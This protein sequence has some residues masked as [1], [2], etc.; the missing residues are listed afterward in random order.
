MTSPKE[1]TPLEALE[2]AKRRWGPSGRARLRGGS[3]SNARSIPGRLARYRFVVGNGKLGVA[4][5]I[6]GQGDSWADAFSDSRPRTVS[7]P[8][9]F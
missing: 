3:G 6:L 9:R 1:M 7:G 8:L 5:S 4:C 2:E